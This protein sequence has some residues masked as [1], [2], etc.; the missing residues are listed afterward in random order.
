MTGEGQ[1]AAA[2]V[3]HQV[4]ERAA[5]IYKARGY[6]CSETVITVLNETFA[7]GLSS[8]VAVQLGSGFCHG[9]GGAGCLCGSLA[10]AQLVLSL[11]LGWRS[12]EGMKKKKAFEQEAKELHDRFRQRFHASCCRLLIKRRK[13]QQGASCLELTQG[14]AEL[15]AELL[16]EKRPELLERVNDDFLK[17]RESKVA[18]LMKKMVGKG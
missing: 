8:E 10:G 11:F 4:G 7:G 12:P 14:G 16:L 6:C 13:K 3:V 2:E 18:G 15:V 5:N 9:M 1:Q 17:Q